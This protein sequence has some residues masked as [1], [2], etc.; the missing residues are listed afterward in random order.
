MK[1]TQQ[2][3]TLVFLLSCLSGLHS[4]IYISEIVADNETVLADGA[5]EYKDW[6]ELRN[7]SNTAINLEGLSLI[8]I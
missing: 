8:H 1:F 3:L 7:T 2:I 6:I 4:Q 5:G